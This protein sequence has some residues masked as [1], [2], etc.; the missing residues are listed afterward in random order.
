MDEGRAML[1]LSAMFV[2]TPMLKHSQLSVYIYDHAIM[3]RGKCHVPLRV[4][5]MYNSA[6]SALHFI[7]FIYNN[8]HDRH[9]TCVEHPIVRPLDIALYMHAMHIVWCHQKRLGGY[10]RV[11]EKQNLP[12]FSF[13]PAPPWRVLLFFLRRCCIFIAQ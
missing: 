4:Y 3:R 11:L 1:C 12:R 13:A 2:Y 7:V 10:F 5:C 6:H 9:C 8:M